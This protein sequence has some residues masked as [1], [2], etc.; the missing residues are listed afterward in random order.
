M[1]TT[2]TNRRARQQA[3]I[4]RARPDEAPALSALALRS[5]AHWGYDAAFL[6]ACREDLTLSAGAV[7]AGQVYLLEERGHP[8]GFYRL[9]ARGDEATLAD[10]FVEPGAIGR[11]YGR[12]LW[13]HAVATAR[14][15]GAR[16]LVLQSEPHA[17]GFYRAMGAERIG[18]AP[19]TV[20]PGRSLPLMHLALDD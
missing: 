4:R 11:G 7:G 1:D 19:S 2:T 3:T 16:R 15:L 8:V 20:F 12:Q 6:E 9:R 17:E 14:R 5:K 13:E 10:L 18:E